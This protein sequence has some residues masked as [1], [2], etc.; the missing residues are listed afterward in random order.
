MNKEQENKRDLLF[1]FLSGMIT[2]FSKLIFSFPV[3]KLCFCT[4]SKTNSK[5]CRIVGIKFL[6]K[7]IET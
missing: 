2:I 5:T 1:Y 3:E 4:F 6:R 7:F